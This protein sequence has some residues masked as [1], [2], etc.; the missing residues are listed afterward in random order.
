M[1]MFGPVIAHRGASAYAPENTMAAFKAAK[2][3]GSHCIEFDVMLSQDGVPFVFHDQSLK[4]I[5]RIKGD[6]GETLT[7][8][9][10]K[11]DAG[12]WFSSRFKH[13]KIP[14][15]KEVL[16]WM[17]DSNV[18]ANI[19]IKPYP[20]TT[21]ATTTAILQALNRYWPQDKDLPIVSS[22][23]KDALLLLRSLSP[24]MPIGLLFDSWT[25]DWEKEAKKVN[26]Y[27]IHYNWKALTKKRVETIKCKGYKLFAYTVNDSRRAKQLFSW[28]L[29]AVFSDYPD[30]MT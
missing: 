21:E 8:D 3:L 5:A 23:D 11:L 30:L 2:A 14:T 24:E 17:L 25:P 27:S 9:V 19:E 13:E 28:G 22:F 29:D 10:E 1:K 7:A 6:F 4:R 15:L 12:N 16:L 26:P 18:Q 20:G